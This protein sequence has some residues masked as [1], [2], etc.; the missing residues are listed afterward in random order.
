MSLFIFWGITKETQRFQVRLLFLAPW[1]HP[2]HGRLSCLHQQV[3]R[4]GYFR[5]KWS[6]TVG[7]LRRGRG[8]GETWGRSSVC[9]YQRCWRSCV[10]EQVPGEWVMESSQTESHCAQVASQ[11]RP[12]PW[13]CSF[14]EQCP[15]VIPELTQTTRLSTAYVEESSH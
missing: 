11:R 1:L 4:H 14:W 3:R 2:I 7:A 8:A 15:Q 5:D 12:C 9:G 10:C 13:L 6:W